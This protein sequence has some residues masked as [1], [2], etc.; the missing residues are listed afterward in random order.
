MSNPIT[1]LLDAVRA[2]RDAEEQN[3]LARTDRLS[4]S[5]TRLLNAR[6]SGDHALAEQLHHDSGNRER[7]LRG[8]R[9]RASLTTLGRLADAAL[10]EGIAAGYAGEEVEKRLRALLDAAEKLTRWEDGL[11]RNA[12]LIQTLRDGIAAGCTREEVEKRLGAMLDAAHL[13]EHDLPSIGTVTIIPHEDGS[14]A[15]VSLADSF[16]DDQ[17]EHQWSRLLCQ[18]EGAMRP[19]EMLATATQQ[20]AKKD[21]STES[22]DLDQ[23]AALVHKKKRSMERYKRQKDDPLPDPDFPGRGGRKDYW[24]WSTIRPWLVRTFNLPIPEDCPDAYRRR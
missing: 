9:R 24:K 14:F 22:L 23:I 1:V 20:Q 21:A 17:A 4:E 13:T 15:T 16:D 8:R 10:P 3:F 2:L 12:R 18:L 19:V 11:G 6:N 5:E 7:L